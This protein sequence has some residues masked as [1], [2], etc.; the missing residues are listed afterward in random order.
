MYGEKR[1]HEPESDERLGRWILGGVVLIAVAA[2]V[3]FW[4][5]Q[6]QD[7][8]PE[9]VTEPAVATAES[10]IQHPIETPAG[11]DPALSATDEAAKLVGADRF[12]AMFVPEDFL[13]RGVATVDGR[14]RP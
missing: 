10:G 11:T 3:W 12:A 5:R 8:A 14:A 6:K 4:Q 7:D 13:R 1:E 2:G 9:P